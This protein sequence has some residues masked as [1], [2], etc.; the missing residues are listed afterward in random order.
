MNHASG[1]APTLQEFAWALRICAHYNVMADIVYKQVGGVDLK[2]DVYRAWT[3]EPP[4]P[5]VNVPRKP[6]AT[7]FTRSPD[8][9]TSA[10]IL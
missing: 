4:K 9:L 2:L 10:R 8:S 3:V 1:S 7:F 5:K 6:R